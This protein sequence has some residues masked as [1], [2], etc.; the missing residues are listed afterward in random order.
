MLGAAACEEACARDWREGHTA[1]RMPHTHT[2]T[3]A[4]HA[5]MKHTRTCNTHTHTTH[6]HNTHTHTH[7]H[8]HTQHHVRPAPA[9]DACVCR[10][11]QAC[12]CVWGGGVC[13]CVCVCMCVS[14]VC[15][16]WREAG[17]KQVFLPPPCACQAQR[18]PHSHARAWTSIHERAVS[19]VYPQPHSLACQLSALI[20]HLSCLR[21][22]PPPQR[23]PRPWLTTPLLPLPWRTST[24][25]AALGQHDK[26]RERGR[27]G[28]Q[29]WS[30]G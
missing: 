15:R 17:E 24:A 12:M 25:K 3:H 10:V 11:L 23:L 16:I 27:G 30:L 5:H 21:F 7:T 8:T 2:H 13:V 14:R 29:T 9:H 1:L 22:H 28:R 18:P 6:T 20:S 4:T 26:M 19:V